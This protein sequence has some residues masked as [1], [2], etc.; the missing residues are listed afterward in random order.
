MTDSSSEASTAA[1][2]VILASAIQ[3]AKKNI[4]DNR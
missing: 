4:L 3:A 1:I 2:D